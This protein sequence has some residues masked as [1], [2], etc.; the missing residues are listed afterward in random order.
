MSS[1]TWTS[2]PIQLTETVFVDVTASAEGVTFGESA[3]HT[4]AFDTHLTPDQAR[5]LAYAL[6]EG[7]DECEKA[8]GVSP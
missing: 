2:A 8:S 5:S 7:A 3:N 4:I 1:A 6:L